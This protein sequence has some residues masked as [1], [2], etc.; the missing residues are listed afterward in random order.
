MKS[1]SNSRKL[2]L[3]KIT[4]EILSNHS[5]SFNTE[6]IEKLVEQIKDHKETCQFGLMMGG[7]NIFR[8]YSNNNKNSISS[9]SRHYVGM[10]STVIN[11]FI[12]QDILTKAGLKSTIFSAISCPDIGQAI[13]TQNIEKAKQEVDCLI[14]AAGTGNPYFTTDTAAALRAL[15]T[16]AVELWKGTKVDGIYDKD[17]KIFADAKLF[18]NIS[19]KEFLDRNLKILDYSAVDLARN[20]NLVIRVFNIFAEDSLKKAITDQN[21]GSKIS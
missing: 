7:G 3:L 19:Y 10:F 8:G 2:V 18:E 11:S 5:G 12:L 17:P 14:F 9:N 4:G 21:Y 1:D 13:T 6:I 15:Q 20:N 16:G